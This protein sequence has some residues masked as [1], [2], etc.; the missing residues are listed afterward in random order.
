M[1]EFLV[2]A[3][4]LQGDIRPV[5]RL[6]TAVYREVVIGDGAVPDLVIPLTLAHER[7]AVIQKTS[8]V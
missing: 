3:C 6:D 8:R 5:P 4:L 2:D 7:T 1:S